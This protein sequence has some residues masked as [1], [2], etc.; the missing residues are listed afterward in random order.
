MN[1]KGGAIW[2]S[3]LHGSGKT[4]IANGLVKKLR[5]KGIAVVVLDG[6]TV[7][8]SISSDLGYSREDRDKHIKRVAQICELIS[9]NGVLSIACVASPTQKIRD[10]AKSIIPNFFEVYVKC[11]ID[12]CEKR[13]VKGHYKKARAGEEG[14]ENF[15]G[16][17]LEYEEP[18]NPDLILETDKESVEQSV[19]KLFNKLVEAKW[20]V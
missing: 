13:D 12:V 20:L 10:F 15:L 14:F 16:V 19:E 1:A 17:G 5:E 8:K 7:R 2:F 3:G 18:K 6:D 4:T 9:K 11:S